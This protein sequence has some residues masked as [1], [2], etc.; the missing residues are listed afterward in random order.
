[1]VSIVMV[2]EGSPSTSYGPGS[3]KD[4]DAD[5]RRHDVGRLPQVNIQGRW[6]QTLVGGGQRE[7]DAAG[8]N[9]STCR[10]RQNFLSI[11]CDPKPPEKRM[12]SNGAQGRNRTTDTAIFSRML[13]QLSYLGTPS[14]RQGSDNEAGCLAHARRGDQAGFTP[15]PEMAADRRPIRPAAPGYGKHRSASA[16]DRPPGSVAC[17][18]ACSA[19]KSAAR[20]SGRP[21]VA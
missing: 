16:R 8:T 14:P 12:I 21:V 9:F 2:G 13:Y 15:H 3:N 18:T 7:W 11:S 5:L 6:Y 1:M 10:D 19:R 4:V 20:R 17:R